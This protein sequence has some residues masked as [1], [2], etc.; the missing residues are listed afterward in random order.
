MYSTGCGCSGGYSGY[1]YYSTGCGCSGGYGGYPYY[2]PY[3]PP[4]PCYS[5]SFYPV[6]Y[7]YPQCSYVMP[8]YGLPLGYVYD[9]PTVPMYGC[10]CE[11]A[12]QCRGE[13]RVGNCMMI[14]Q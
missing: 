10:G 3:Y 7:A 5:P 4:S 8:C 2:P 13:Y 6:T 11:P 14:C 12:S 9:Y 1:P